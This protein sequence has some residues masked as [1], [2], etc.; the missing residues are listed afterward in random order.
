MKAILAAALVVASAFPLTFPVAGAAAAGS[1]APNL[2]VAADSARD[3]D[4]IRGVEI[5]GRRADDPLR[6]AVDGL[7]FLPRL[8]VHGVLS[9]TG[10][11]IQATQDSR[12]I[13]RAQDLLLFLDRGG[14]Y[15]RV[16][17]SSESSPALGATFFY[18]GTTAGVTAGGAYSNRDFRGASSHLSW[19]WPFG[20]RVLKVSL[21][22]EV[23]D[24]DDMTFYGIGPHPRSD[25]RSARLPGTSAES[26]RYLQRREQVGAVVGL[27]TA[28]NLELFWD[29]HFR[30]RRVRSPDEG[31]DRLDDVFDPDALHADSRQLATELSARWDTR[32]HP[33]IL[34]RGVRAQGHAGVST[35]RGRDR[36][37]F[38]RAGADVA[39][40]LPMLRDNRIILLRGTLD[41]VENLRDEVPLPFPEYPRHL[42]FRG[43]SSSHTI[44]RADV[45]VLVPSAAYQWPLN[46]NVG[47]QLFVDGLLVAQ[48]ASDLSWSGAP[49]AAGLA[50]EI[51]TRHNGLG[52]L[53]IS[54]GS[55]GARIGVDVGGPIADN[56]RSE[57]E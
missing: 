5:R 28:R 32:R 4:D 6:G 24:R 9:S 39:A 8:A 7:L 49:W 51:H 10:F 30:I 26:A 13:P 44:L 48:R 3:P 29:S 43:T 25:P 22:G 20:D 21:N 11:G 52:R 42:T 37:R 41:T 57:W 36:S 18:R 12:I 31:D 40:M 23:Q 33:G 1:S 2:A 56:N 16:A 17:L 38:L 46:D 35:G 54:G 45:W 27:R 15:P 14:V 55:E 34:S 19:Q 47:A 53:T 50:V